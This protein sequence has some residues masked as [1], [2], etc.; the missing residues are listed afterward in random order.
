MIHV[1]LDT[2][3]FS[4]DRRRNSGA[5][6]AFARLCKGGKVKLHIPFVVN[7]EF[8]SQQKQEVRKLLKDLHSIAN[9]LGTMT[10]DDEISGFAEGTKK[11]AEHLR[12]DADSLVQKEWEKW[13]KEIGAV[14]RPVDPSHG[15][16]VIRDYFAGKPPFKA[17]RNR[18]DIPDSYLWQTILDLARKYKPLR[19]VTNDGSVYDA[20]AGIQGT[21]GQNRQHCV[22]HSFRDAAK[23]GG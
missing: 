17:V 20:A 15:E 1:V 5:F 22:V 3:V 4:S 19:L 13:L 8:L 18:N 11:R 21:G 14:E 12:E 10:P 7:H 9:E 16:R 2:N 23:R 6:R